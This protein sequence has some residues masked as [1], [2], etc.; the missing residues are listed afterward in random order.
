M[1]KT[2]YC[3]LDT[4]TVGGATNP[5][6]M[7]NLG[8]IIHDRH[9]NIYATFSYLIAEKFDE[10]RNDDYAKKNFPLYLEKIAKGGTT[11]V[12]TEETAVRAVADL[13]HFYGVRYVMAYNSAFDFTKTPCRALLDEFEFIDIYLMAVQTIT[14]L[15]KYATF[16]RENNLRARSGKSVATTAEAMYAFITNNPDY[17]EEHTAFEDSKIEM[18]IF[19]RA[20]ATHKKFTKN[21]HQWDA[22]FDTKYFPKWA[23]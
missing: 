5:T 10:I 18:A 23:E 2:M 17:Q 14:P 3:T 1:H 6:G 20:L 13:L 9:G 15:K 7:Y 16:C 21:V 4:E 8:G 11:M 12:D 22:P 19:L